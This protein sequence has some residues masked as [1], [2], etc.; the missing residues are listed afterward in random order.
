MAIAEHAVL[1][2]D[3]LDALTETADRERILS[4]RLSPEK[5]ARLDRLLE[6]N[7]EGT[8]TEVE[9]AE[10]DDFEHFEH[11]ARLVKARALRPRRSTR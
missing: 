2:D 10:L 9:S 11:L 7:R 1:Y 5:Q 3:L 4:C 6:R 8:L